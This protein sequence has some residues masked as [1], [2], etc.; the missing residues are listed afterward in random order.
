[1][2]LYLMRSYIGPAR[3]SNN[4]TMAIAG[5]DPAIKGNRATA[6]GVSPPALAI[7]INRLCMEALLRNSHPRTVSETNE[8]REVKL[9][10]R[11]PS[12]SGN[13]TPGIPMCQSFAT[14]TAVAQPTTPIANEKS[15]P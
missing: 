7:S 10:S 4:D 1:M 11:N 14:S 3:M 5:V 8:N 9:R 13:S 6:G 15:T 2:R 12:A